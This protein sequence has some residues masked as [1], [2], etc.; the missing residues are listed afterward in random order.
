MLRAGVPSRRFS[1][2]LWTVHDGYD[3]SN[4]GLAV[5]SKRVFK[6]TGVEIA[7]QFVSDRRHNSE[8]S[9]RGERCKDGRK[10]K[11]SASARAVEPQKYT[12]FSTAVSGR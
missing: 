10:I 7:R 2:A 11:R 6:K 5:G 3:D 4:A 8:C 9:P 1:G 12:P